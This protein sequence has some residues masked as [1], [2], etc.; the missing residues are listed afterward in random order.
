[1][2]AIERVLLSFFI[3]PFALMFCEEI[4][5][6]N[7]QKNIMAQDTSQAAVSAIAA[8]QRRLRELED[9]K[10][11]LT[12]EVEKLNAHVSTNDEDYT[13][14]EK[15]VSEITARAN[16]M[17]E[18]SAAT[19]VQ[20]QEE[21]RLNTQLK[22]DIFTIQQELGESEEIATA[23]VQAKINKKKQIANYD[24]ILNEYESL[25]SIIFQPPQLVGRQHQINMKK[26]DYDIDLLPL[27][28]R[29]IAKQLQQLP[30]R[31][32][33]QPL[34]TKR[35]MI[36]GLL[37]TRE[38][39]NKL[40]AKIYSL[41]KKRSISTTPRSIT[42]EIDKYTKQFMILTHEMKRFKFN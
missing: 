2:Q 15:E 23:K 13:K 10:S 4:N 31:Y 25:L 32:A 5:V 38:E 34:N 40:A 29:R 20:I 37:C 22:E 26:S 11:I 1:M 14:R 21:R 41:E 8:L 7:L 30:D 16:K 12:K 27:G 24:Q 35:A 36:Q 18:D 6:Q 19:L 3:S 28:Q 33:K 9:E 17:L 39:A 42:F